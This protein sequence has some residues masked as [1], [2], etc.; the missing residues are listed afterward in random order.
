VRVEHVYVR[1]G[2]LALL[3]ALDVHNEKVFAATPDTTGIIPFMNLIGQVMN[4]PEYKDAP[5]C[6]SS[7]TTVPITA[8]KPPLAGFATRTP[9]RS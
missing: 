7:W 1:H 6:S 3:T 2:A 8:A 4:W 5:G 9:T